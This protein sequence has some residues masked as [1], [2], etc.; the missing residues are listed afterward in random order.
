MESLWCRRGSCSLRCQEELC[1][2][3]GKNTH[4]I[5]KKARK[6]W[7][8][9]WRKKGSKG[10]RIKRKTE[11]KTLTLFNIVS[12]MF[13]NTASLWMG[14]YFIFQ[15]KM[16]S[17]FSKADSSVTREVVCN[18][19]KTEVK[20]KC[21]SSILIQSGPQTHSHNKPLTIFITTA[22]PYESPKETIPIWN[23]VRL[24][25]LENFLTAFP[26]DDGFKII[27]NELCV[28]FMVFCD[29]EIGFSG[30]SQFKWFATS[31]A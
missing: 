18:I 30:K 15:V 5:K 31:L 6:W 24:I 8:K 17:F 29:F 26:D 16:R 23:N 10:E 1:T 27:N 28:F 11:R 12:E 9:V 20:N 2:T 7:G 25:F 22:E 3:T 13:E 4:T 21:K 19:W 14:Q